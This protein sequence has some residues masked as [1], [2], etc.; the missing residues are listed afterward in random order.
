MSE[1]PCPQRGL[2]RIRPYVPGKP[3]DEVKRAY[4][5][6][7]VIKLASNENPLG[8]SPKALDAMREAL[9]HV[10]LYPDASSH[11]LRTAIGRRF[12][13]PLESVGIGNGADDLILQL[14][15]ACLEDGDRVIASRSSFPIYDIYTHAMRAEMVKTPLTRSYGIDLGAMADAIDDRTKLVYVCN[16]NNPTGTIVRDREVERFLARVP[17]CVIVVFDEAYR[18]MAD[19]TDFPETLD[20]VRGGRPNIIVLRTF[21]KVYGMA[22]IRLGYGFAHPDLIATLMRIKAVFNVN[23]LAQA[24]GIAALDDEEFLARSVELNRTGRARLC[25]EFDRLG[26]EYA[27]SHTNFVLVR[28]GPDAEAIQQDLLKAGVIVRPCRGYDLPDFLRISIG[29][30]EQNDR[31]LSELKRLLAERAS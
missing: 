24:A 20:L 13:F 5:L 6:Q 1:R 10:N 11:D 4:G 7:D 22:G 25:E 21:S 15:M 18:E 16:P 28:I 8:V 30:P 2:E 27:E 19:A 31:V 12:G 26:L 9:A 3:I 17:E 14:S 29:T 23:V